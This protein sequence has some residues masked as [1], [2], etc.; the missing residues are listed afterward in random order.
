MVEPFLDL[1]LS[2]KCL[3]QDY[4][5]ISALENHSSPELNPGFITSLVREAAVLSARLTCDVVRLCT[6]YTD[7]SEFFFY[8]LYPSNDRV[9]GYNYYECR[10][11]SPDLPF[12]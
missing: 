5:S 3:N 9:S 1:P 10:D 6:R 4:T 7:L 12:K 11:F 2:V 8:G